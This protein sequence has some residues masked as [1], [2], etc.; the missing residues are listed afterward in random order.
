[1]PQVVIY[2]IESH[3]D[4]KVYIG[5]TNNFKNRWKCH[6]TGLRRGNHHS[7]HLQFAWVKY[8]EENFWL[9]ILTE[10]DE[11]G[12]KAAEQH[13][14]DAYHS[15]NQDFGY[16]LCPNAES[17]LGKKHTDET[18]LKISIAHIGKVKS[19]IHRKRISESQVGKV[20]SEE[21]RAK[22]SVAMTG[23]QVSEET[24][25]KISKLHTGRRNTDETKRRMS[26]MAMRRVTSEETKLKLSI[27]GT[28]RVWTEQQREKMKLIARPRLTDEQRERVSIATG[29]RRFTATSESGETFTFSTLA[30]AKESLGLDRSNVQ[31]CLIGKAKRTGGYECKYETPHFLG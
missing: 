17:V 23:R 12:R 30:Q 10:C 29:G 8:G 7:R 24:R 13:W 27:A 1:M 11:A 14:M 15:Y 2:K 5:S 16:N 18:R 19:E 28:G 26:E 9:E 3:A 25:A 22:M 21:Y 31:K 6:R 4:G 20:V